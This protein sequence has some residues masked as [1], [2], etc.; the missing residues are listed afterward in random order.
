MSKARSNKIGLFIDGANLHA[1]ARLLGF[2]LDYQRLLAEFQTR[3]T[4]LRAFYYTTAIEDDQ[5][6]SVR[7]LLDWLDYNA[8]TVVTKPVKE[9]ADENGR[10]KARGSVSVELTVD[11]M[12]L[13][14]HVDHIALF[15][16]N[17]DFSALVEAIQRRGVRVT[18]VS[19]IVS[20]PPMVAD[21]LRR[22]ADVFIDL[23][24]LQALIGRR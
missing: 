18:V 24:D 22:Q 2:S 19:S 21:E 16:G 20:Q 15:S 13:A 5:Y 3:G 23:H 4:L 17:G 1:T 7:P 11:A 10:R 14:D 6:S 9:Y 12:L 8:F